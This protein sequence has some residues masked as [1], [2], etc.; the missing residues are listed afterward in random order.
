[1]T[2]PSVKEDWRTLYAEAFERFHMLA[3]WNHRRLAEPTET[4]ALGAAYS[5]RQ[6]GDMAARR[7][8]ERIEA[9]VRGPD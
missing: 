6:E 7:L 5:L 3:L 8:A 2:A 9:A 1:M 4:A